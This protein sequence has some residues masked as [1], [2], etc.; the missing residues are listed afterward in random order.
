MTFKDGKDYFGITF[1]ANRFVA[2]A[3]KIGL[4]FSFKNGTVEVS[5]GDLP[6]AIA[7]GIKEYAEDLPVSEAF[8]L[9][10]VNAKDVE[11]NLILLMATLINK[12]HQ[13]V[14]IASDEVKNK[15]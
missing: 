7:R 1:K 2:Y 14:F 10:G 5:E 9:M 8:R 4:G 15:E 12:D 11:P 3:A 6:N 13:L